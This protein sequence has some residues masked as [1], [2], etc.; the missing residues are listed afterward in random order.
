MGNLQGSVQYFC[1]TTGLILKRCSF[2][3]MTMPDRV[4]KRVNA[5]RLQEK[6][7]RVFCFVNQSKEPYKWTDFVPEDDPRTF[8]GC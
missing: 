3:P 8:R 7:G 1:L 2:T 6:Q 5:I 4:I